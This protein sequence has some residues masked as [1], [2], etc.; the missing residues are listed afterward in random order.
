MCRPSLRTSK[1]SKR[2]GRSDVMRFLWVFVCV[3]WAGVSLAQEPDPDA[4]DYEAW[5]RV[6]VRAEG[7]VD[8]K[9]ASN[10]AFESLRSEVAVWRDRF[11][12][13]QD[14]NAA[15]IVTIRSKIDALGP[16]PEDGD[17][18]APEIAERRTSLAKDLTQAQA[19][20]L[21]AEEAYN[22]ADGLAR[23][24]DAIIRERQADALFR[25]G[26]SPLNPTNWWSAFEEM[27]RAVRVIGIETRDAWT[28][29]IG[30]ETLRDALPKV[31][32]F[33]VIALVFLVRGQQIVD[34]LR[35]RTS[36]NLP[37]RARSLAKILFSFAD[38]APTKQAH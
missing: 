4:L 22:R 32:I 3:V 17:I 11:L 30:Q 16:A 6:A 38:R 37:R 35:I 7:A 26:P 20:V 8:V 10:D 14:V 27:Q 24:I 33:S 15:R 19:P 31:L 1:V 34:R 23:E 9:R 28:S 5:E 12:S 25:L 13:R 2:K 36:Q 29:D 18:E 21:R